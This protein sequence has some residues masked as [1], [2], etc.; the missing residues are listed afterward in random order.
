MTFYSP[1]RY[2]GGKRKLSNYLKLIFSLN[3]LLDGVYIEP[4]AG[5]AGIALSLL[6][7]EY[8]R[9]IY[10]NDLSK[11]IYS[12]W[13]SVLNHTKELCDLI[14][15]T[16][17]TVDE[18]HRQKEVQ[19][20]S[21]SSSVIELGFS[22]FFLNRTNRSGIL[23][24]GVIGG[25]NQNSKYSIDARFNK[26]E[27]IK[28]IKRIS[29]YKS[30]IFLSNEDACVF[31]GKFKSNMPEKG[32]F[33][34]DPP[35]YVKGKGL[36]EDYYEHKDHLNIAEQIKD[37]DFNWIVSYDNSPVI[38]SFYKD[39]RH[40]TYSLNYSIGTRYEGSE[41]MF[42]SDNLTVPDIQ[43]PAKI[44]TKDLNSYISQ[45]TLS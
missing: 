27:L 21:D 22:T 43:S 42:F 16:E 41:V 45:M 37:F 12:F 3:D 24:G 28:R 35:Y 39:F 18:W 33:Y 5:G 11:P 8:A 25:V 32:L 40:I 9:S 4:Y 26:V 34:F 15:L 1:L 23:K 20:N 2:P 29:R 30:R 7:D 38:K 44:K 14:R 10:I 6:F 36:Y 31:I 17:I 19:F 13:Y